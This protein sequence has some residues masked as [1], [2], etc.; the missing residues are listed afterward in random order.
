MQDQV[1]R[2]SC[3]SCH[4]GVSCAQVRR[5]NLFHQHFL[6]FSNARALVNQV[7]VVVFYCLYIFTAVYVCVEPIFGSYTSKYALIS[8]G[9]LGFLV[10]FS[11]IS[12]ARAY[13]TSPGHVTR[14]KGSIEPEKLD[15]RRYNYCAI[16][17]LYK[18]PRC[19]HCRRCN[20]CVLRMDHHWLRYYQVPNQD[21]HWIR[22]RLSYGHLLLR[23]WSILV[24]FIRGIIFFVVF[25]YTLFLVRI[26]YIS[27]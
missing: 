26:V 1:H 9:V 20:K 7:A 16:C 22:T 2:L 21:L 3:V 23:N 25:I 15:T 4:R 13:L 17:E 24:L 27:P 6:S 11:V 14:I 8:L 5:F 18:P 10:L 12:Y 19:H